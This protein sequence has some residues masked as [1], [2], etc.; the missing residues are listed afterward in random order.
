VAA[1]D[2]EVSPETVDA[3][4]PAVSVGEHGGDVTLLAEEVGRPAVP[5]SDVAVTVA[6]PPPR[7]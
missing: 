6:W 5:V 3:D 7:E 2:A 1:Y 4:S